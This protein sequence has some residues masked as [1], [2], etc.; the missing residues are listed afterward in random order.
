MIFATPCSLAKTN[1]VWPT[2][3]QFNPE[4]RSFKHHV[5]PGSRSMYIAVAYD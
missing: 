1:K 2:D 3:I 5:M 4:D